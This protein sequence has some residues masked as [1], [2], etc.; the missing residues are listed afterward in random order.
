MITTLLI[1]Y[2]PIRNKKFKREKKELNR[3]LKNLLHCKAIISQLKKKNLKLKKINA[4]LKQLY[5]KLKI[6]IIP[7]VKKKK[8]A[9]L[10]KGLHSRENGVMNTMCF[11]EI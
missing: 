2:T 10:G 9:D 7:E 1:S 11:F 6:T 4:L 8:F 3:R 5:P